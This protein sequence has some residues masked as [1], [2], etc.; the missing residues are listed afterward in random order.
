MT[1]TSEG[2]RPKPNPK[3]GKPQMILSAV[4]LIPVR[5]QPRAGFI[6]RSKKAVDRF[7]KAE[8]INSP[9]VDSKINAV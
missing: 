9:Y 3:N 2:N 5:S 7:R 6:L 1:P 4:F 8:A